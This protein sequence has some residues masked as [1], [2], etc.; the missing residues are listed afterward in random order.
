MSR[1]QTRPS[2]QCLPGR[3]N[4]P[5]VLCSR[6]P[7]IRYRLVSALSSGS[8]GAIPS[9]RV[10]NTHQSAIPFLSSINLPSLSN[11]LRR[12]T[13]YHTV[14][15][16]LMEERERATDLGQMHKFFR[17]TTFHFC[18]KFSENTQSIQPISR[19]PHP[20]V[21]RAL[22]LRQTSV[23]EVPRPGLCVT[24]ISDNRVQSNSSARP[25]FLHGLCQVQGRLS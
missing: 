15:Q 20:A 21:R 17:L 3:A 6:F 4:V 5:P 11:S 23:P 7:P 12:L 25:V 18:L 8:R 13:T 16:T 1:R 2:K 9:G 14:V 24:F 10:P 22:V 19:R